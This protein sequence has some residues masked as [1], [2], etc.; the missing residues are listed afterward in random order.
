MP[1]SHL[2]CP[3]P[4][5]PW[6]T[7]RLNSLH[8]QFSSGRNL[9]L[10]KVPRSKNILK[11][12]LS[13]TTLQHKFWPPVMH[14]NNWATCQYLKQMCR[15]NFFVNL[16]TNFPPPPQR[17]HCAPPLPSLGSSIPSSVQH[18]ILVV[19]IVVCYRSY[20]QLQK[21]NDRQKAAKNHWIC[22]KALHGIYFIL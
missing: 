4:S 15:T 2:L 9:A 21:T 8:Y 6:I 17:E 20:L 1:L 22:P 7:S 11:G 5:Y 3:L 12:W 10:Y 14:T 18:F 16:L 13:R 19:L